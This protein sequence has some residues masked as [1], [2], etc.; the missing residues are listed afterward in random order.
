MYKS[1]GT[2]TNKFEKKSAIGWNWKDFKKH[3]NKFLTTISSWSGCTK[4]NY[5][6]SSKNIKMGSGV[7]LWF[8]LSAFVRLSLNL[9]RT[10][11]LKPPL[12]YRNIFTDCCF[13]QSPISVIPN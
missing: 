5:F 9:Q 7:R 3:Y 1:R 10:Y 11:Y 2:A 12:F 13:R 8:V 6:N 4:R